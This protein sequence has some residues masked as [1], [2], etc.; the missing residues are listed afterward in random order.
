[1]KSEY[2]SGSLGNMGIAGQKI[3]TIFSSSFFVFYITVPLSELGSQPNGHIA[4]YGLISKKS[5][6]NLRKECL[7]LA[8]YLYYPVK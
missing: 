4:V 5:S 2:V 1:M 6:H 8:P 7:V 3:F